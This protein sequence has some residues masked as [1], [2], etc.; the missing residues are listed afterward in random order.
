MILLLSRPVGRGIWM[1]NH[2]FQN[3]QNGC[4]LKKGCI[5]VHRVTTPEWEN[6]MS[7]YLWIWNK[8][9]FSTVF[10]IKAFL[11]IF[12][13]QIRINSF[14]HISAIWYVHM[15]TLTRCIHSSTVHILITHGR[16]NN[17]HC[18]FA[19]FPFYLNCYHLRRID[20]WLVFMARPNDI[21][22]FMLY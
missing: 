9:F 10:I 21:A 22:L 8:R 1:W 15:R 16:L 4:C 20:L 12:I 3:S 17:S 19:H 18:S 14:I 11:R 6:L 5:H 7:F 13:L 2:N